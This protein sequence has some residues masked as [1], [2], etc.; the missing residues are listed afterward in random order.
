MVKF[1][2]IIPTIWKGT[3]LKP[4]LK[5]LYESEYVDEVI[6][7]NNDKKNTPD[8]FE[9]HEKLTYIE[10]RENIFVNPAW[11]LGVQIARN[12][13]III[14][15]DD[16]LFD[17]NTLGKLMDVVDSSQYQLKDLGIMGMNYGNYFL[18]EDMSDIKIEGYLHAPAW[19]CILVFDKSVWKPI[20]EQLKIWYGDDYIKV[21]T[22]P[23]LQIRGLKVESKI[24]TSV[25]T[26]DSWISDVLENDRIEWFKLIGRAN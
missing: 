5:N 20:P 14:A 23:V 7:I 19:A 8:D 6:I 13:K 3:Y 10:T 21:T 1:S 15:Q 2:V 18:D 4:L 11:N 25:N 24:S 17:V 16:V 12:Q 9:K 26:Q 22:S